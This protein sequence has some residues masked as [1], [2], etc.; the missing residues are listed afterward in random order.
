MDAAKLEGEKIV[1]TNGC[2]DLLHMGHVEYL[3]QAKSLGDRL[4]VAVNSDASVKRLKG[5]SRPILPCEERVNL[6]AALTCVDFVVSFEEDT[7]EPLLK[8]LQPD[9][10]VKG[11]D[12]DETGIVGHEIVKAYGGKVFPLKLIP[13]RST[14]QIIEKIEKIKN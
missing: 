5:E 11:G 2:F 4:I 10:L 14:T 13:G 3:E 1:F 7:P 8:L 12:Y 6:L 9:I